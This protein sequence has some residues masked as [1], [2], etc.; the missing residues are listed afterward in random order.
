MSVG[1]GNVG[2][3]FTDTEVIHHRKILGRYVVI[4]GRPLSCAPA[5]TLTAA[6]SESTVPPCASC[7]HCMTT[8]VE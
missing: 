7:V 4:H 1:L 6:L 5:A 8:V 3:H 2:G